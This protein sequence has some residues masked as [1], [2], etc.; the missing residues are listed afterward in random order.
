MS[1]TYL[2]TNGTATKSAREYVNAWRALGD[3]VCGALG[4]QWAM[5]A[6]DPELRLTNGEKTLHI[7]IEAARSIEHLVDENQAM[8]EKL[9]SLGHPYR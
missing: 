5:T 9:E 1:N 7:P 8:R 4:I 6:F 3:K 2:L